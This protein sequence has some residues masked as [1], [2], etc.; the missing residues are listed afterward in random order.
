MDIIIGLIIKMRNVDIYDFKNV[1]FNF[2][3]LLTDVNTDHS[4]KD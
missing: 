1:V 2:V 4:I 3:N